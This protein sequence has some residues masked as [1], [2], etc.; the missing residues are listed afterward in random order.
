VFF[1]E[2]ELEDPRL[3]TD[4]RIRPEATLLVYL[5]GEYNI[6]AIQ[7]ILAD[8]S[9]WG[10]TVEVESR[11]MAPSK[12]ASASTSMEIRVKTGTTEPFKIRVF[13]TATI[14]S[15][16]QKIQATAHIPSSTAAV[17]SKQETE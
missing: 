10:L 3:L 15:V 7:A 8:A 17:L 6:E 16:K 13:S 2:T 9:A 12:S 11:P 1:E 14:K 5:P 4:Y